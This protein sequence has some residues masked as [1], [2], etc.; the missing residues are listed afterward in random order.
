MKVFVAVTGH[1]FLSTLVFRRAAWTASRVP[2]RQSEVHRF[3]NAIIDDWEGKLDPWPLDQSLIDY[4]AAGYG[5]VSEEN[6][7]F[8]ANVATKPSVEFFSK[9]I[10][11]RRVSARRLIRVI[12][13]SRRVSCPLIS[14][15]FY[16]VVYFLPPTFGHLHAFRGALIF[17]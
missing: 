8:R 9:P 17:S 15:P 4:V 1:M 10:D 14:V 13:V 3:D 11:A 12:T 7:A 2:Y 6:L 5:W 16:L